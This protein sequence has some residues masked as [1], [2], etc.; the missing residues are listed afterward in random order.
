M[1]TQQPA[2]NDATFPGH[3]PIRQALG[4]MR[5]RLLDLTGRNRLLNYKPS[6]GKSL[7]FV[8]S[9]PEAAYTRL[10]ST[11]GG[12]VTIVPVPDPSPIEW[13]ER[14]GRLVKPEAREHAATVGVDTSY[15]LAPLPT[16]AL[17][18]ADGGAQVRALYYGDDLGKHC[19]KIDREAKLA[20]EETGANMLYLVLAFLE[21]PEAKDSDILY[22]APLVSI[23]VRL[24]KTDFVQFSTYYMVFTGE[25]VADNISLREKANRGF[26]LLLP[27]YSEDYDNLGDYLA[28]VE[29]AIENQPRWRLRRA[30]TLTLL[31]FTNMLLVRDLEPESWP[32]A[33]EGLVG[34]PI[35]RQVFEG[36]TGSDAKYGEEHPVDA[37]PLAD[38]PLIADA[39]SSQHSALIDFAQGRNMVIEGPPGTGKSQTITNLIAAALQK[40]KKV[41]FVAEKLAALQVVKARLEHA[42]L[43]HFVLELHSNKTNKKKVLEELDRRIKHRPAVPANFD[44]KLQSLEHKRRDLKAY[45]ELLNSVHS[46]LQGLT[47]HQVLWKAEN[48]R[49][50]APEPCEAV[51]ELWFA[52]APTTSM[53]EYGALSDQLGYLASQFEVI[54]SFGPTHPFWGFFPQDGTPGL[55]LQVERVLRDIAPKAD[56]FVLGAQ[57]AQRIAG[58]ALASVDASEAARLVEVLANLAP[59][60]PDELAVEL[61]PRVFGGTRS[62]TV[63]AF[64]L[65]EDLKRNVED[66][67]DLRRRWVRIWAREAPP[68]AEDAQRAKVHGDLLS[69]YAVHA[70]TADELLSLSRLLS[71]SA[72]GAQRALGEVG[73]VALVIGMDFDGSADSLARV[74]EVLKQAAMAPIDWLRYRHA[75]LAE[76]GAFECLTRAKRDLEGLRQMRTNLGERL[77]LDHMPENDVFRTA[78]A[79]LR[80]GSAWY[81]IFQSRWRQAITLHKLLSKN[82][83]AKL[84]AEQRLQQLEEVSVLR[85]QVRRWR[86]DA[87]T[88]QACGAHFKSEDTEFDRL[89]PVCKWAQLCTTALESLQVPANVFAP[90]AIEVSKL[91]QLKLAHSKLQPALDTLA[92]FEPTVRGMLPA[93]PL[94]AAGQL[95][96]PMLSERLQQAVESSKALALAHADLLTWGSASCPANA[97][98]SAVQARQTHSV[99]LATLNGNTRAQ[100]LLGTRFAGLNTEFDPV[101]AALTFGKLVRDAM[102]PASIE[103][104]LLGA[105]A[106]ENH[107]QLSAVLQVIQEGWSNIAAFVRQMQ[108]LGRL[109]LGKWTTVPGSTDTSL[110]AQAQRLQQRTANALAGVSG[111]MPW[112][113][114]NQLRESTITRGLEHFV[115]KMEAGDVSAGAVTAV[116]GYRFYATIAQA[117]F[118]ALPALAQF[119]GLKHSA[120]RAE[121]AMLDSAVIKLRG[122]QVAA[123]NRALANPPAGT[124]GVRVDDRTEMVLLNHL[125]PQTRPRMPVRKLMSRAG[126]AV[127]ELK[128]CFMMGPQAVA[129]FL[130][131]GR[132]NFDV[133]VMD[134]ASQ[135][136]PEQAIGAIARG[137]QL[138]VVGDPKQLPP[139]S[140]FSKMGQAHEDD[141]QGP[142]AAADAESNLDVC[143]GHFRPV[144]RLR[145]H[146]RSRHESL[147]A[148]SNH[149]FYKDL[150][151]FPSPYP[152]GKALGV[153]YHHVANGIY[154]GQMNQIEAARVVDA[155]ID[156]LSTRLDDSLGVVT[157]NIK[158]KDLIAE[159]LEERLKSLPE[160][161][162]LRNRWEANGTPVFIKNLENVQGDERDCIVISTTFGRTND[163]TRPR[164]NFGPIS[165]DGGWRRLKVLFT[166][167]RKSVAVYSAMRPEDIVVDANTPRGTKTLRDYLEFAQR[168][169]LTQQELT[170]RDPD[171]EFEVSVM[172]MLQDHGFEVTPQLGVA[173]FRIDLAV[174]HPSY[175]HAYLAAIECDGASY[176]SGV[177]VRDRDRI[178]QE[179][180]ESLGWKDRIWRIWSTDWFR[181]PKAETRK[182]LSYLEER[183]AMPVPTEYLT[184]IVESMVD[185]ATPVATM[186][187]TSA[188]LQQVLVLEDED[189][190]IE[191]EVGDNVNYLDGVSTQ[192]TSVTIT[193]RTTNPDQGLVAESTPLA[194][195]LLGATVGESVV[196]RVPGRTAHSL[197]LLSINRPNR[198]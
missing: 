174:K 92:Q 188:A 56:V 111:L 45:A 137:K 153:R 6:I 37:H 25:E 152:K 145:W 4:Q 7:Q 175:P 101:D 90:L 71:N 61:L 160:L 169:I 113:Q 70:N 77:Y 130:E 139:T 78:I 106:L 161:A 135:L 57:E 119:S 134:E 39:D 133:V 15:D 73:P 121:F 178:R 68:S 72:A 198:T 123:A 117:V 18:G 67:E 128:P 55:D 94:R 132:F 66:I 24:E 183:R 16:R 172:S 22:R 103:A 99:A 2:T 156:H 50:Q 84:S 146:Y 157:L 154:E 74:T 187:A 114:Y 164:Q 51:R 136:R 180:L 29:A 102:V 120:V 155:V 13:I 60:N 158:Q 10:L 143:I 170:G 144:R 8:H 185:Q 3:L 31:S 52:S 85:E 88:L 79:T 82:K 141:E 96:S 105:A 43:G 97:L 34:H 115:L 190:D 59:T 193:L 20:I 69:E 131:P 63:A 30:M 122:Q 124:T 173:G 65:V 75:G 47:V 95:S 93:W 116:F 48:C 5:M 186:A 32:H 181:D 83:K 9:V 49:R 54:G 108:A 40:G 53:P 194:Q 171:S 150:V 147:I 42:Q 33:G 192:P 148:F 165:R 41:L 110:L 151:V 163:T 58:N 162:E 91:Q 14:N 76:P 21:Y 129:Q 197:T 27:E 1:A 109:D 64:A 166:R 100:E 177:S 184:V 89:L 118:R 23:P 35:V 138:I 87:D 112:V 167:A 36:H 11:G 176:H 86:T 179:I 125:I 182:L 104:L 81:R 44:E 19:R 189:V 149:H 140:F 46:N 80:E 126:R 28:Q 191:V 195:A 159:L 142:V 127:Q 12:R 107:R 196:L 38:L 17:A 62:S 26:G 168:G 98:I